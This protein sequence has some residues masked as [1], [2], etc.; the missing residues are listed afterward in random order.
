MKK[1][2]VSSFITVTP[3]VKEMLYENDDIRLVM[4]DSANIFYSSERRENWLKFTSLRRDLDIL[5]TVVNEDNP[6][7]FIDVLNEVYKESVEEFGEVEMYLQSFH[8]NPLKLLNKVDFSYDFLPAPSG[9]V[10]ENINQYLEESDEDWTNAFGETFSKIANNKMFFE[11]GKEYKAVP[12]FEDEN[13]NIHIGL[14]RNVSSDKLDFIPTYNEDLETLPILFDHWGDL[15]GGDLIDYH[16]R[17][18]VIN[19]ISEKVVFVEFEFSNELNVFAYGDRLHRVDRNKI[20]EFFPIVDSLVNN[21]IISWAKDVILDIKKE[22]EVA[23]E[24]NNRQ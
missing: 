12:F 11:Y 9:D 13:G 3:E 18:I 5:Y 4:T 22:E 16:I 1:I 21:V 23:H 20:F 6:E 14:S 10:R 7:V 24:V 15:F 8:E 19:D 17:H 2:I